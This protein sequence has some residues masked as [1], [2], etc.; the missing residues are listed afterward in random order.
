MTSGTE[1]NSP[2]SVVAPSA[3]RAWLNTVVVAAGAAFVLAAAGL[4]KARDKGGSGFQLT[5]TVLSAL[6]LV[7]VLVARRRAISGKPAPRTQ[8]QAW[9]GMLRAYLTAGILL[10]VVAVIRS[11]PQQQAFPAILAAV[12]VWLLTIVIRLDWAARD[13]AT[14]GNH[15]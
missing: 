11:T 2:S 15:S 7:G 13:A 5:M 6:V 14:A 10:A 4:G 12:N 1:L 8:Q 9:F 3:A